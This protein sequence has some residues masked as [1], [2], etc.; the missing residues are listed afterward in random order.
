MR[1]GAQAGEDA[2]ELVVRKE[3]RVAAEKAALWPKLVAM[4]SSYDDYQARTDRDIPVVICSPR[5]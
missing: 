4:Y 3:E 2:A 5:P 1:D